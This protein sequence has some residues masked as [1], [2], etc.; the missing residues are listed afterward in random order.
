MSQNF[1]WPRRQTLTTSYHSGYK[2]YYVAIRY[3]CVLKSSHASEAI[4]LPFSILIPEK[5]K[6]DYFASQDTGHGHTS[7]DSDFLRATG[8]EFPGPQ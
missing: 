4:T 1:A 2:I 7:K 6:K 8:S 5:K 3:T